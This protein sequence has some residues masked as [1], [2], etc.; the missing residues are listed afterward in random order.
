[1]TRINV[2]E[3]R[4]LSRQHL[5][6]EYREIGRVYKLAQASF[7][8][9]PNRILPKEYSMGA[10]HVLFFFDKLNFIQERQYL[11][12]DEMLNRGY[13]VNIDP[14]FGIDCHL[15]LFKNKWRPSLKDMNVNMA[16]LSE[17][18]PD[19]YNKDEFIV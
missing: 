15:S 16:R 8:K 3:P 9:D 11:L 6:A 18:Q 4:K 14:S 19:F 17:R 5:V 12:C 1:M 7:E 2:I 10:G 13:K